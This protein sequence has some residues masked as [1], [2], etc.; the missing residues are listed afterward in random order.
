MDTREGD[1]DHGPEGQASLSD[2]SVVPLVKGLALLPA[3][4]AASKAWSRYPEIE[5]RLRAVCSFVAVVTGSLIHQV[6]RCKAL[7][8]IEARHKASQH[9]SVP[10]PTDQR[11]VCNRAQLDEQWRSRF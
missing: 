4:G 8:R 1:E 7:Q 6:M 11:Q 2:A 9:L 3:P 10:K 5:G